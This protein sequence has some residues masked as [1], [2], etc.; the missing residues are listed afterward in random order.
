MWAIWFFFSSRRRHTRFDCDWSSDVCS[1]DLQI[2]TLA[3]N[4]L[5]LVGGQILDTQFKQGDEQYE[6]NLRLDEQ[7][8]NDPGRLGNLLVPS[9]TQRVVRLSDVAQLKLDYGPQNIQRY[10]RQRNVQMGTS[11]DGLPLGDAV[12][13]AGGKGS[14]RPTPAW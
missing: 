6:I 14:E 8:R 4:I 3:S 10:A 1:S 5:T 2:D 9:A 12:A 7:F 13:A 11:L